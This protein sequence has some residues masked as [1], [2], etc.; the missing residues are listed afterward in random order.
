[1]RPMSD[2]DG[3]RPTGVRMVGA[4]P[5]RNRLRALTPSAR[6]GMASIAEEIGTWPDVT[7]VELRERSASVVVHFDP[8][9]ATAVAE[10]LLRLGIDVPSP[11]RVNASSSDPA[12]VIAAGASLANR[13][14]A[15]RLAGTDLRVLVPLGLGMLAARQ[16]VR[17]SDRLT[18]A[19]WYVLAWYA[20]E[21]FS[22][23]HGS[24]MSQLTTG[25]EE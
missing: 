10:G 24:R 21:T 25:E 23:F 6:A 14:V 8:R 16:A 19:P 4:A 18:D 15:Q 2:G 17:G 11:S 7:S 1:M 5:G 9:H 22:K 3:V 12:L 13:A 20:S